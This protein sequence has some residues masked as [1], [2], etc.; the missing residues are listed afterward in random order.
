MNTVYTIR[1]ENFEPKKKPS[2]F[3]RKANLIA[4]TGIRRIV[5]L[6]RLQIQR[7]LF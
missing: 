6:V 3:H 2:D 4:K 7:H 5:N 1:N